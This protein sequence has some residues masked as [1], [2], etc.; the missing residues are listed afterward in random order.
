MKSFF[1]RNWFGLIFFS[2]LF[3]FSFW[4]MW[5][6]FGY[7]DS[8]LLVSN[9]V[10]SDFAANLPLIR[11]FSWGWNFPLEYPIFAGEPIK[12]HFLFYLLV[13]LLE[14]IGLRLDW[15]LN[16]PSALSFFFLTVMIY[17]LTLLLFKN[18]PTAF[19]SVIFFLFNGSFSF[20]YF[21]QKYDWTN[22]SNWIN[23]GDFVSFMPYGPGEITAFWS[24]NT[25]I[26]Q[27]HLA[28]AFGI[29]L[30]T[31]YWLLKR[32]DKITHERGRLMKLVFLG[33]LFGL[34]PSL[35]KAVFLMEGVTLFFL[36]SFFRKLRLRICLI[37]LIGLICS[38]PQLYFTN[39]LSSNTAGAI[40][41]YPGYLVA[42]QGLLAFFRHWFLN[43]GLGFFL[44]PL[45]FLFAPR[46]AKK[47]GLAFLFL[48][49]IGNLFKFGPSIDT[50]HKFFNLFII[51]G[52]MYSA[53]LIVKILSLRLAKIIKIIT[54]IIIIIPMTL[55]GIIDFF[56]LKNSFFYEISDAP[57]NSE[58]VW[59]KK[60]TAPNSLFLNSSY[61]YYPASLAG[62]RIFYGWPYFTWGVGY[63]SDSRFE[64]YK[65]IYE[66]TNKETVCLLLKQNKIDYW[67]I[68]ETKGDPNLPNI[69]LEFFKN[70]FVPSFSS[71]DR[72]FLIYKTDLNC[73]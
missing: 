22:W 21:F 28:L 15:A 4:L 64:I 24:L 33:I 3:L 29:L 52:N 20:I 58:I 43:L 62:R 6:S 53:Y 69:S 25:Y 39:Q 56:P 70:N 2:F 59:I 8:T 10:W 47:V 42:G 32:A 30:L 9:R 55:S 48:F 16:L 34:F 13:G 68:E 7:K 66:S 44:I 41:Y 46:T 26:N 37:G 49:V 11:S 71:P 63:N 27:R 61:L 23:L 36:F 57:K 51:V 12:Y 72:F 65:K 5:H 67:G 50:N 17:K 19:L 60:N 45:G 54:F 14:R 73:F 18:K 1:R 31:V 40:S 35:H 38:L